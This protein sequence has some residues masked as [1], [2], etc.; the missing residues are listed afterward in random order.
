MTF[1]KITLHNVLIAV[2][3]ALVAMKFKSQIQGLV[4]SVPVI[5]PT[6]AKAVA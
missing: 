1:P 3:I 6:V 2:A 5:G 4:A